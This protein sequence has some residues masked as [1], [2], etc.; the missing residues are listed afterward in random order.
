V[1]HEVRRIVQVA[2]GQADDPDAPADPEARRAYLLDGLDDLKSKA[3]RQ[4]AEGA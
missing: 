4:F 2:R 1:L 3:V